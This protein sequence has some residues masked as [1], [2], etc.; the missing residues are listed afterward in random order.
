MQGM[1]YLK[2]GRRNARRNDGALARR[3]RAQSVQ[4]HPTVEPERFS[5]ATVFYR[6]SPMIAHKDG[7]SA[8]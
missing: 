5:A 4:Q 1:T 7:H 6:Y 8:G 2:K 3:G